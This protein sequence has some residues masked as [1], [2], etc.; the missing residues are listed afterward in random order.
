[1]YKGSKLNYN[2]RFCDDKCFTNFLEG[3]ETLYFIYSRVF[4]PVVCISS[5]VCEMVL[6]GTQKKRCNNGN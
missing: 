1:M 2:E 4:Q 6:E 5:G 3:K